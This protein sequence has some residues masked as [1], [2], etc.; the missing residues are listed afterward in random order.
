M[1]DKQVT[2]DDLK[3]L[4]EYFMK[5]IEI[6]STA[7]KEVINDK[8]E[9]PSEPY[10]SDEIDK[11][12]EALAAAQATM[13]VAR[14][15]SRAHNSVYATF[16]DLKK[17]ADPSLN[18]NGLSVIQTYTNGNLKTL[19]LHSSGQWISSK[20]SILDYINPNTRLSKQQEFGSTRSYLK[21]YSYQ[22]ITGVVD[23]KEDDNNGYK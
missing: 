12:A 21:R 5:K 16:A 13:S 6:L 23:A 15:D 2:R 20:V 10:R 9:E 3:K 22:D 18:K 4:Q 1:E 14:K 8:Q 7:V 19:L 17:A 11:L